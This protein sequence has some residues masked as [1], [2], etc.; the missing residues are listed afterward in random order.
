MLVFRYKER[1]TQ[2][3]SHVIYDASETAFNTYPISNSDVYIIINYLNFGFNFDMIANNLWGLCPNYSWKRKKLVLP[4]YINGVVILDG[5]YVSGSNYRIGKKE[6]WEQNF[7][8][9]QGYLCVGICKHEP[10][11]VSIKCLNEAI[12]TINNENF[13]FKYRKREFWCIGYE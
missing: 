8:E 1:D 13:K 9:E 4:Q 2:L 6:I 11:D 12:A 10:G 7:D 5:D 3:D